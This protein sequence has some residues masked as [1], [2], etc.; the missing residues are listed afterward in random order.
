MSHVGCPNCGK[1]K[2]AGETCPHCHSSGGIEGAVASSAR[3]L[4]TS[5]GIQSDR[6]AKVTKGNFFIEV[7]LWL[8][9]L[10]PGIIYTIWRL[11]TKQVVCQACGKPTLIPS[12]S[13]IAKATLATLRANASR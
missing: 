4:C 8:C 6:G 13:P 1:T 9:F 11:T 7:I 2:R 5:C 10:V 3:Y 12:D